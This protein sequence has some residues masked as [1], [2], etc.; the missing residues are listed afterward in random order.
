M[1]D[2]VVDKTEDRD[3]GREEESATD[4]RRRLGSPARRPGTYLRVRVFVAHILMQL[5][6]S[7]HA[8]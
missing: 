5:T 8:H 2:R 3:D 7:L 1:N 6:Q 4:A